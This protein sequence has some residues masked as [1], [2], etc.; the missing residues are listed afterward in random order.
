MLD[1]D[2]VE[3]L[4]GECD[5][6][7]CKHNRQLTTVRTSPS[8]FVESCTDTSELVECIQSFVEPFDEL[9]TA[10][11]AELASQLRS[12]ALESGSMSCKEKAPLAQTTD[13]ECKVAAP[14]PSPGDTAENG[15]AAI[16]EATRWFARAVHDVDPASL[17]HDLAGSCRLSAC[18]M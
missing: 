5:T 9:P 11:K 7:Q 15:S 12:A 18:R 4:V 6:L 13:D 2:I 14:V 1:D 16:V 8:G 10:R 3:Y 17:Q